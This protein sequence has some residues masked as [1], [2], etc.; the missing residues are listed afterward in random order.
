M[1][2]GCLSDSAPSPG[3]LRTPK[4]RLCP[5]NTQARAASH[6]GAGPSGGSAS[7][8]AASAGAEN[9]QEVSGTV[10]KGDG[11]QL[12]VDVCPS[13]REPLMKGA[14]TYSCL[15]CKRKMHRRG[16]CTHKTGTSAKPVCLLCNG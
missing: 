6:A 2:A 16:K 7:A 10:P 13:C 4:V 9:M 5:K 8:V 14:K 12:A 11:A 1:F 3:D 15:V